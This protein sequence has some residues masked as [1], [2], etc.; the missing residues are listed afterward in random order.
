MPTCFPNPK[1]LHLLVVVWAHAVAFPPDQTKATDPQ[2]F[3]S[4]A[5]RR[6]EKQPPQDP[7]SKY[8]R[9]AEPARD[10]SE[11]NV[12]CKA[13]NHIFL[14]QIHTLQGDLL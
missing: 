3:I 13:L 14:E 5:V 9:R 11:N 1:A 8:S 2:R 7:A 6:T 12:I 10:K 4:T